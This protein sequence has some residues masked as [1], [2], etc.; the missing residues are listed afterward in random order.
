[1]VDYLV[2]VVKQLGIF[3]VAAQTLLHFCPNK[4]YEK[5]IRVLIGSM[6]IVILVVPLLGLFHEGLEQDIQEKIES[7]GDSLGQL[8][9]QVEEYDY[10]ELPFLKAAGGELEAKLAQTA[11]QQGC[12]VKEVSIR[13]EDGAS[14]VRVVVEDDAGQGKIMIPKVTVGKGQDNSR[15]AE[16]FARD[17]GVEAAYL[18]VIVNE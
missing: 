3:T 17:L 16:L 9:Q 5:Y 15:L 10:G 12:R 1:M 6:S 7:Y 18:E 11:A 14:M 2:G 8:Q 13:E 4:S